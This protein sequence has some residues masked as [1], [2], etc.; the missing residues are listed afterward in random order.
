[1]NRVKLR[2]SEDY[3]D[4]GLSPYSSEDYITLQ[5]VLIIRT[6]DECLLKSLSADHVFTMGEMAENH[7]LEL[8]S[9]PALVNQVLETILV[10]SLKKIMLIAE[11][12]WLLLI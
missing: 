11:N 9:W 3:R 4:N 7:S 12:P 8:F 10:N 2:S 5:T 1:L 6:R